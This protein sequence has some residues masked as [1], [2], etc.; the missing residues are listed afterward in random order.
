LIGET[1]ERIAETFGA[2]FTNFEVE[3]PKLFRHWRTHE[4][5]PKQVTWW[6]SVQD[7]QVLTCSRTF[8]TAVN[9]LERSLRNFKMAYQSPYQAFIFE[10]YSFD[11]ETNIANFHYS[12]DGQRHFNE[13][14]SF[15]RSRSSPLIQKLEKTTT[16]FL[17]RQHLI[18]QSIPN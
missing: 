17:H 13:R 10:D 5:T 18:L 11:P 9:N 1:K 15:P 8:K 4:K 12:F 16:S 6:C 3:V 2:N 14:S 7:V